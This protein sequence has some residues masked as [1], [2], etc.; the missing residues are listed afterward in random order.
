MIE[1]GIQDQGGHA[2]YG[3]H[4]RA[5]LVTH[6]SQKLALGPASRLGLLHRLGQPLLGRRQLGGP[7]FD[8]LLKMTAV[9]CQLLLGLFALGDLPFRFHDLL[10]QR[11][12]VRFQFIP[13]E[14]GLDQIGHH[15]AQ[16]DQVALPG[17][18]ERPG[19]P[20]GQVQHAQAIIGRG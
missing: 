19:L 6:V 11:D 15:P 9:L 12:G 1:V 16:K 13:V 18:V 7:L 8:H 4:G 17:E 20:K 10:V 3:V 5:D 14:E 2:Y